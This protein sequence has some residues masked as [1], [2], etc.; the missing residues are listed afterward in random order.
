[1][2]SLQE[3]RYESKIQSF[4]ENFDTHRTNTL[5][6]HQKLNDFHKS[7]EIDIQMLES[8]DKADNSLIMTDENHDRKSL[9]N[10]FEAKESNLVDFKIG[11][12]NE[13]SPFKQTS[14]FKKPEGTARSKAIHVQGIS[15]T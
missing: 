3:R 9:R 1:M 6:N 8:Y 4:Q 7:P 5:I 13:S 11:R 12:A 2:R 10:R 15:K 14:R